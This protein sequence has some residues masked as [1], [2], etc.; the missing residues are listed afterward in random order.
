MEVENDV[1][2]KTPSVEEEDDIQCQIDSL[3]EQVSDLSEE[4]QKMK[5][6]QSTDVFWFFGMSLLAIIVSTS[7]HA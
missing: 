5:V 6:K 3:F 2:E 7:I 4:V 1:K